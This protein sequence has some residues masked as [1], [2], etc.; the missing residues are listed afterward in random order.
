MI[1]FRYILNKLVI[2]PTTVCNLNCNYCY[3]PDRKIKNL[4]NVATVKKVADFVK[5]QE[6]EFSIIWHGGEPLA[7]GHSYFNRLIRQ[8]DETKVKHSIQ[9]NGT[10]IC[11]DW[12]EIFIRYGIN[13]GVSLD[14]NE[15]HNIER[16]N[17]TGKPSFDATMN[18]ISLLKEYG[19]PFHVICVIHKDNISAPEAIYHFFKDLGCWSVGFNIEEVENNNS[20]ISG[21]TPEAVSDF[22]SRLFEV[23]LKYPAIRIREFDNTLSWLG[24]EL[25]ERGKATEIVRVVDIF[26]SVASNGDM[27]LLS[28][29]FLNSY[30]PEYSNFK[31]GNIMNEGI[32]QIL[33]DISRIRYVDEFKVGIKNC[34]EQCKYFGFC[35]GGFASN[36]YF[37]NKSLSSTETNFCRNSKISL[38]NS[39]INIL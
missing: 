7:C 27:V 33:S 19:I 20:R 17:W 22:W 38:L 25:N 28:P 21:I 14:G 2:Q 34:F 15:I 13:V 23:W 24:T 32:S 18:G 8:F 12:C 35:G 36:K 16:K 30:S 31:V 29:E 3:L 26:P 9:T 1:T 5:T 4:M 10:L 11:R 39:V 6:T 37:E